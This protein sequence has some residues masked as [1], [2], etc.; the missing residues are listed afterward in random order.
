MPRPRLL[1][2]LAAVLLAAGCTP[3]PTEAESPALLVLGASSTRVINEE[4]AALSDADLEFLN[5]G[6]TTLVQQLADGAPGDVLITAD[7]ASMEQAVALGVARAPRVV[8]INSMVM[9]VPAGNP[10]GITSVEDLAGT[11]LVLCDERVPCGASN[12]RISDAQDLP[13]TPAFREYSVSDVLAR[14]VSGQAD[15]GW[16]YRTDALDAGAAVEVIDIPGAEEH[17]NTLL[18]A[19]TTT[20]VDK[21]AATDLVTLLHSPAMARV[22]E[23]HGFLPAP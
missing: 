22:W 12:R 14:V 1:V 7:E 8:A 9:V 16:V 19:V 23:E 3:V 2:P 13:L 4:L 5:A 20:A 21:Q 11:T 6:T 17:P 10:A 18:A 15:A